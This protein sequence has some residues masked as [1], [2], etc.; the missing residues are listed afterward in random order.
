LRFDDPEAKPICADLRVPEPHQFIH[1]ARLV[2]HLKYE[3]N[4]FTSASLWITHRGV[5]NALAKA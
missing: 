1:L 3:E 4:H 2:A 5:W